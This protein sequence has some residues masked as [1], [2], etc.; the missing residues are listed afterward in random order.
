MGGEG[1]AGWGPLVALSAAGARRPGTHCCFGT[2]GQVIDRTRQIRQAGRPLL[3]A[4]T[5]LL[6]VWFP[7]SHSGRLAPPPIRLLRDLLLRQWAGLHV[8]RLA[9]GGGLLLRGAEVW[10]LAR[11][12]VT[13]HAL[14]LLLTVL[15]T[16]LLLRVLH[17]CHPQLPSAGHSHRVSV[18]GGRAVGLAGVRRPLLL[19]VRVVAHPVELRALHRHRVHGRHLDP[20]AALPGAPRAHGRVVPLLSSP[21]V[22]SRAVLG[23]HVFSQPH[24]R[25][26]LCR[27]IIIIWISTSITSHHRARRRQQL[28]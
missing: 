12:T 26:L 10:R 8:R 9:R 19:G 14:L 3:L 11:L 22:S 1:G 6:V 25:L 16:H 23:A 2:G 17:P 28:I 13:A 24:A 7:R 27:R 4:Q 18:G 15:R 21:A 5:Q 20:A